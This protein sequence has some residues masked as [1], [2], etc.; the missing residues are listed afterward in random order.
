M[1]PND[2]ESYASGGCPLEG[3]TKLERL[4]LRGQTKNSHWSCRL[5]V[6]HGV[7]HSTP[8]KT[9]DYGN[10]NSNDFNY[11]GMSDDGTPNDNF[12]QWTSEPALMKVAGQSRKDPGCLMK[13]SK[14]PVS[15][16]REGSRGQHG[17]EPLRRSGN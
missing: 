12:I 4:R 17:G 7:S 16:G 14:T 9:V 5:G 13:S 8:E 15:S 6:G 10:Y 1:C 11:A 2:A 3:F